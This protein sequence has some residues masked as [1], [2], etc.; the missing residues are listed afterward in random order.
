MCSS[1]LLRYPCS[2][3]DLYAFISPNDLGGNELNDIWGWTDPATNREYALVGLTN[4]LSFVDITEPLYTKVLGH[5]PTQ[6]RSSVWRDIKVYKNHAFV[7]AD[8]VGNH[9][10]QVFDLTQLRGVT[11]FTTFQPNTVYDQVGSVHNIAINE[12]TGYAYA[13]GTDG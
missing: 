1:D 13:V 10:V 11:S 4:G 8:N 12:E 5:L 9:G 2:G 3:I 7:V 6:T